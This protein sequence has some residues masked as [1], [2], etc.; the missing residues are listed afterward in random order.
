MQNMGS[1]PL[2]LDEGYRDEAGGTNIQCQPLFSH[3]I[4]KYSVAVEVVMSV[5]MQLYLFMLLQTLSN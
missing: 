5:S 2:L 4:I 3:A 1:I